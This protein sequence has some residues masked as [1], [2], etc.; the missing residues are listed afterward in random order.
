MISSSE[1]G[2]RDERRDAWGQSAGDDPTPTTTNAATATTC[3]PPST[4][5]GI[6]PP[7]A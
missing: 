2:L 5:L 4:F 1:E 3:Q 7:L 6:L